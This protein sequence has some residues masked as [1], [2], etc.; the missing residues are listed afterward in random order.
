[1]QT[2]EWKKNYPDA[3]MIGVETLPEKKKGEYWKFDEGV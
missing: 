1:L 2:A 3:K